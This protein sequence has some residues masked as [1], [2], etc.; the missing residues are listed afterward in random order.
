[1]GGPELLEEREDA[2]AVLLVEPAPVAKLDEHLVAAELLPRPLEILE[3]RRLADDIRGELNEDAPELPRAPDR[4]E[5]LVEASED[6]AAELAR[7]PI[8]PAALV[9]R[10]FASQVGRKLLE[11]DGVAGHEPEGLHV[12]DEVGRRPLAPLLDGFRLREAVVGGI[13]LD[14][15]EVLGVVAK[16]LLARAH[17]ARVPV[18]D[19][20]LVRPRAGPDPDRRHAGDPSPGSS[21][22][23][24]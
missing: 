9:D 8:D 13:D 11:L 6:L 2:S 16:A 10:S 24:D 17:L 18:L 3:G 5:R 23:R 14:G 7:R 1:V 20:R 22:V 12:E 19:E 21:V 4:L 15:R